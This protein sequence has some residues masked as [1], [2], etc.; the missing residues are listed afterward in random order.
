MTALTASQLRVVLRTTFAGVDRPADCLPEAEAEEKLAD[1]ESDS[2]R[3][4][5]TC[6][7]FLVQSESLRKPYF[8]TSF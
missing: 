1:V 2:H 7:G 3:L 4:G 5:L 6:F 8:K